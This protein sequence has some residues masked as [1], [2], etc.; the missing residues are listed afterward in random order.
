MGVGFQWEGGRG[1]VFRLS[2]LGARLRPGLSEEMIAGAGNEKLS[3]FDQFSAGM[4][5][6]M[7]RAKRKGRAPTGAKARYLF[8]ADCGSRG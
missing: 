5:G 3:C 8:A 7:R 2:F 1:V 4:R 6:G